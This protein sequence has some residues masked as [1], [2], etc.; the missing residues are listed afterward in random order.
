[1]L[2]TDFKG[3]TSVVPESS[4]ADLQRKPDEAALKN[5]EGTG[6]VQRILIKK[7]KSGGA[8]QGPFEIVREIDLRAARFNQRNQTLPAQQRCSIGCLAVPPLAMLAR[9]ATSCQLPHQES[10][11]SPS[12][13]CEVFPLFFNQCFANDWPQPIVNIRW[14]T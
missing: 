7:S 8:D 1:M 14:L 2:Q 12:F 3:M 4:K 11:S 9:S 10:L 13:Q 5:S 6:T